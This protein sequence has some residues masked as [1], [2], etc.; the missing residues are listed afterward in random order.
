MAKSSHD[1]HRHAPPPAP[2]SPPPASQAKSQS[3][4]FV[5]KFAGQPAAHVDAPT[6]QEAIE[7]AMALLG[8]VSFE[9]APEVIEVP[10]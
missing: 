3:S 7:R 1:E 2:P 6:N 10:T 8:V 4:S 5:V 9:T